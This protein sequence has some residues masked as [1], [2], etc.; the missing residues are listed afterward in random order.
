MT[1]LMY[2]KERLASYKEKCDQVVKLEARVES[3]QTGEFRVPSEILTAN[4][5]RFRSPNV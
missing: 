4:A 2:Q 1:L 5:E 3:Y